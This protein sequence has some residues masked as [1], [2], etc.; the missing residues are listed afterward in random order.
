LQWAADHC[1]NP[2]NDPTAKNAR[3]NLNNLLA[4]YDANLETLE[5]EQADL[6]NQARAEKDPVLKQLFV[7]EIKGDLAKIRD[8]RGKKNR[9]LGGIKSIADGLNKK[10]SC[11]PKPATPPSKSPPPLPGY[12]YYPPG[13]HYPPGYYPR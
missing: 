4:Q 12:Y 13:G 2:F 10:N 1:R 8:L 3:A 6:M 5:A 11:S 9:I 7:D